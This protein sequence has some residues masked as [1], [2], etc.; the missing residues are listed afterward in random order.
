MARIRTNI[1]ID[2]VYVRRIMDRYGIH[3]KT[4]AVDL[5][6]RHL[7]GQPMTREEALAMEGVRA[8]GDIPADS[9]PAATRQ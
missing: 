2:D 7:A 9:G 8:I 6:L 3:T 4:E 5:A 1:E